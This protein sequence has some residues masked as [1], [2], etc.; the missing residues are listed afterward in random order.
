MP[1]T[2]ANENRVANHA[3]D[4]SLKNMPAQY[5]LAQEEAGLRTNCN[6]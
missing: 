6:D 4:C 2:Q 5:P 1:N 3:R